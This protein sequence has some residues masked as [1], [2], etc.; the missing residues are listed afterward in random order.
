MVVDVPPT[1]TGSV[2]EIEPFSGMWSYPKNLGPISLNAPSFRIGPRGSS[3][4]VRGLQFYYRLVALVNSKRGIHRIWSF[5]PNH[6]IF[7]IVQI[8]ANN[9][10]V[11]I[12]EILQE[13]DPN[14]KILERGC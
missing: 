8:G 9:D 1:C 4:L 12:Q 5:E 14:Q 11:P 13:S 3:F 10:I 2:D 7:S 6:A